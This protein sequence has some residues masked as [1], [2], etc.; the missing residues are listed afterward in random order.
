MSEGDIAVICVIP[1]KKR[2]HEMEPEAQE[3]ETKS[4]VYDDHVD[5]PPTIEYLVPGKHLRAAFR[6]G[7]SAIVP[8]VQ[9][10]RLKITY[11]NCYLPGTGYVSID[12]F[13]GLLMRVW[14]EIY[15]IGIP[16]WRYG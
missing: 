7:N 5:K 15:A 13:L 11:S 10:T 6:P 16:F 4:P 3:W 14:V 8:I 9:S 2:E 12:L 1:I